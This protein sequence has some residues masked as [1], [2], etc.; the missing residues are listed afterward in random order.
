[1]TSFKAKNRQ[2]LES[3]YGKIIRSDSGRLVWPN[4]TH[5]MRTIAIPKC[6]HH[7]VNSASGKPWQT[8][9]INADAMRP[10]IDVIELLHVRD[11]LKEIKT[12]D[13]C[14]SVRYVR[15]R[16]GIPSLHCYGIAIDLNAE[17]MPL[18]S[19]SKWS[20][21]FIRTWKEKGWQCGK[22]FATRI[23]AQHFQY[24]GDEPLV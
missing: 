9:Y 16:E 2:E 11:L 4:E 8:V 13:G 5:W 10:L 15:G 6:A 17:E 3:R 12:F 22:D 1:M 24:F 7:I 21:K 23:D 20:E 18:G 19:P 14:F